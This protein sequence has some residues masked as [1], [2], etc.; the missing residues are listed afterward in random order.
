MLNFIFVGHANYLFISLAWVRDYNLLDY[1]SMIIGTF[2][3]GFF[4]YLFMLLTQHM[5]K[6]K[7]NVAQADIINQSIANDV[8]QAPSS[9]EIHF[10]GENESDELVIPLSKLLFIQS[11]GNYI[12][13]VYNDAHHVNKSILRNSLSSAEQLLSNYDNVYRCHRKFLVNLERVKE[14]QGNSQGY[15]LS[16]DRDVDEVPVAR[17]KNAEFRDRMEVLHTNSA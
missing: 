16:L 3:V 7:R 15:R 11:S 17:T 8:S 2:A 5:S 12:E 4:P 1:S 6:L 9:Q 13:V 10:L 14:V